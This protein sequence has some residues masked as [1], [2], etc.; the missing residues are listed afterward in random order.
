[1]IAAGRYDEALDALTRALAIS[2]TKGERFYA[3]ELWRLKSEVLAKGGD[4]NGAQGCLHE[5][6]E[7]ARRQQARLFELRSAQVAR[8]LL[9]AK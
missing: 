2:E 4:V 8:E 9:A 5:A 6:I 1:L 7:V 3:A